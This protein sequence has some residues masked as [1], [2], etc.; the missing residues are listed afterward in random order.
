[1]ADST[2]ASPDSRPSKKQKNSYIAGDFFML[3]LLVLNL[4]FLTFDWLFLSEWFRNSVEYL[5]PAF[6]E[7]YA[8]Q[9]HP[10]FITYD[11]IF[12]S[13]FLSEFFVRWALSV[14]RKE[15]EY[16][17]YFPFVHWYD[18]VGCIPIGGFRF[19]R[20]LRIVTIVVRLQSMGYID[21]KASGP[22]RFVM[23]YFN[24][25]VEEITDQ[26][27]LKIL[28]NVRAELDEGT[29]VIDRI[30]ADV[31]RPRQAELTDWISIRLRLAASKGYAMHEE[32]IRAYVKQR[33]NEAVEKNQELHNLEAIPVM[34]R[35]VVKQIEGAISDIV[36]NVLNG[37][38]RDLGSSKNREFIDD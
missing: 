8:R 28:G 36:Y 25:F 4:L 7:F 20:L 24:V 22:Y 32:D 18:L 13:I 37:I 21:L 33:I 3:L 17:Y 10:D 6:H 30:V 16:W 2:Q 11:L 5:S 19:F 31:L 12:I 27:T 14:R 23:Y 29:P 34:G 35:M 9:I 38:I 15:F 1:M 26:V